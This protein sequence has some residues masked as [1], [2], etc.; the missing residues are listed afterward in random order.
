[1]LR[2]RKPS[3]PKTTAARRRSG[4]TWR[5][6]AWAAALC[7]TATV[8]ACDDVV[9]LPAEEAPPHWQPVSVEPGDVVLKRL[10]K[11]Q[12]HNAIKDLF[13]DDV[14]VPI[15]L[16]PD[17]EE[18]GFLVVGGSVSS[19]SALGVERY[20]SASYEIAEQ[21]MEPEMRTAIMPCEPQAVVDAACVN[22][23]L[24]K[25]GRRVFRRPLSSDEVGRYTAVATKAAATLGDFHDGLVFAIAGL[26]QSPH[27]LFRAE[28]L[29]PNEGRGTVARFG[30]YEMAS[31]LSFFLWNTTPDNAL[32]DAAERGELTDDVDLEL[33]I[34]RMLRS[35]KAREGVRNFFRERFTLW[36]LDDLVKDGAI[37]T[38][39]SA[40]L[41]P[42][43][44]EETL[45]LIEHI[46][47]DRGGDYRDLFTT[48]TS[49]INRRLAALYGVQAPTLDGFGQTEY[50]ATS[51]RR[52]LLGHASLL[53][54]FS[55]PVSTSATLRGKFIRKVLLC[56][57]I[58]PP[59]AD[60][61]TSLPEPSEVHPT[62]RD[63]IQ[64]H[65]TNPNCAACH[66]F[67]DPIGLGLE[68]FDGIGK[69]RTLENDAV[70]DPSGELDGADFSD[71]SGLGQAIHDH[72]D[73][74]TCLVR[75]LYRYANGQVETDGDEALIEQLS[76]QFA[77]D[78]HRIAAL[79]KRIALSDGFR[80]GTEVQP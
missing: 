28:L 59:P 39:M 56:G 57:D 3:F 8:S 50:A 34:D 67:L 47:F 14:A 35:D 49:F 45:L 12:Y 2:D 79:L 78:G 25:F 62:L 60:V 17:V 42:E 36:L 27:F 48:K 58:P 29:S 37:F 74:S 7:V 76:E 11:A 5:F 31:R 6:A 55:H 20:E 23:F 9:Q 52:G 66:S 54:L 71:A 32:L 51:P 15:S 40:D 65:L 16:E 41:G 72:E 77:Y 64:E 80:N 19:I 53:S 44:R 22:M 68:Q 61:D 33:Q 1:M 4:P 43:A 21:A 75:H 38:S 30:D 18:E 13:G 70:I 73:V 46:V 69:Y 63:R 24:T 26:L 10:T